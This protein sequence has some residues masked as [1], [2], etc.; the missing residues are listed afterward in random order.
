MTGNHRLQFGRRNLRAASLLLVA[1][2]SACEAQKPVKAPEA[3]NAL[4]TA[5]EADAVDPIPPPI[6]PPP[7]APLGRAELLA[8]VRRAADAAASGGTLPEANKELVGR[9]FEIRLPFGCA[10]NGSIGAWAEAGHDAQR[11]V[12]RISARPPLSGDHPLL[13]EVA[14]GQPFDRAEGY[15]VERPWTNSEAC[16]PGSGGTGAGQAAVRP[17][18]AIAQFFAPDAPRTLQ[19]GGRPYTAT[20]KFDA[21]QGTQDGYHLALAGRTAAFPDGQPIRCH[22]DDAAVPPACVIN[23]NFT[24]IAFERA[25]DR[26]VLAE[27]PR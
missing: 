5:N 7:V 15:W 17:T 18:L 25:S 4:V 9:S 16:P 12:L 23:A 13:R 24:R 19:R 8:A 27:W 21:H 10:G 11:G 3:S 2:L 20:Q 26:T 22:V 14:T 6:L 1:L